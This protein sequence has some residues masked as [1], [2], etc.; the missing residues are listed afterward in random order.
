MS[1]KIDQS[2]GRLLSL[3]EPF[4]LRRR[5]AFPKGNQLQSKTDQRRLQL[6][7]DATPRFH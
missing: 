3:D 7:D 4:S 2:C 5:E 6:Q 1:G